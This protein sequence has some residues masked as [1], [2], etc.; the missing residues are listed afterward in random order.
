MTT[1]Q[2]EGSWSAV[3]VTAFGLRVLLDAAL[4]PLAVLV[5]Q[6]FAL[7]GVP[8]TAAQRAQ[9]AWM[10]WRPMMEARTRVYRSALE[11]L[12][13]QPISYEPPPLDPYPWDAVEGLLANTVERVK[14]AGEPVTEDNRGDTLAVEQARKAVTRAVSR[15]VQQPA[16]DTVRR[17]AE[18]LDVRARRPAFEEFARGESTRPDFPDLEPLELDL[19]TDTPAEERVA[20]PAR[21]EDAE[22]GGVGWARMLMGATSCA[23]CAMLASRGPVYKTRESATA[24]SGRRNKGRTIS[25]DPRDPTLFHDG[26]DCVAVLV[27]N[28]STWEGRAAFEALEDLWDESTGRQS[29][30]AA[31]NAFRR[32]WDRKVRAGET[33]DFVADSVTPPG[34]ASTPQEG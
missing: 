34:G 25:D 28:P 15:H 10:L 18:E 13:G 26:C 33:R 4:A 21:A 9:V 24:A 17:V 2:P 8:V 1:P 29:N 27:T 14:V 16:R 19:P 20:E 22:V 5:R 12:D 30:A 3:A 32:V 23:F 11:Y 31:R 7:Y 6:V